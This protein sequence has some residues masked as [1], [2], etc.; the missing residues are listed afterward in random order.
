MNLFDQHLHSR[1]SFDSY[2]EPIESVRHAIEIGLSG[3]SFTE[4][5]D[6][7]PDEAPACVFDEDAYTDTVAKL[8][9]EFGR[10]IFIGK[11]VE[12][13]YQADSMDAIVSF[14]ERSGFDVVLL[15]VHWSEGKPI[16]KA[17]VW[18]NRDPSEV[19]RC[20]LRSVL[21]AVRHCERLHRSGRRVFDVLGHMDFCKRYSN[22]F[23]GSMHV[24]EHMDVIEEILTACLAADLVPEV[25]TSTLRND[26]P[27]PMPG[28]ATMRRYAELGGT[29]MSLGSDA[30]RSTQVGADFDRALDMLRAAG[31]GQLA[32]FR[33]RDRQA[34]SIAR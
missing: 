30:H 33:S 13:D 5:Y 1:H 2:A 11:G 18:E 8:R 26:L 7:H 19:T 32:V 14:V 20:Y 4:H 31:V 16:H 28:E 22:R 15:S 23:A 3:L 34:E 21:A 6:T 24:A 10:D 9:T 25:N 29:M 17:D 12:I 27:D